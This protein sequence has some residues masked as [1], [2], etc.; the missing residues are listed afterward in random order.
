MESERSRFIRPTQ[1]FV[2]GY[3][4]TNDVTQLRKAAGIWVVTGLAIIQV[5]E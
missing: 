4:I 3:T 2:S 5:R 1:Q